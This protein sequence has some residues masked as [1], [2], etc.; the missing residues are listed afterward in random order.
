[1]VWFALEASKKTPTLLEGQAS[2]LLNNPCRKEVDGAGVSR[3]DPLGKRSCVL[4]ENATSL[5]TRGCPEG[6]ATPGGPQSFEP[7][8]WAVMA[9]LHGEK[10]FGL[11]IQKASPGQ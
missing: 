8:V 4:L 6:C 5:G 2:G 1:M 10:R 11:I 9:R 7:N 3:T